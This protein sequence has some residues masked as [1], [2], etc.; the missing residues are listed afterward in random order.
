MT[1]GDQSTL[2]EGDG[3]TLVTVTAQ[4]Q[5]PTTYRLDRVVQVSVAGDGEAGAVDFAAVEDF[6]I[7]LT[8][9]VASSQATFTLTPESDIE[10]ETDAVLTISGDLTGVVTSG[11]IEAATLTLADDDAPPAG[12]AL[13]LDVAAAAASESTRRTGSAP[14]HT[15]SVVRIGA[16]VQGATRY[17]TD[18]TVMVTAVSGSGAS[19]AILG[20][21]FTTTRGIPIIIRA[22]EQTGE[23]T[24][25]VVVTAVDDML[26]ENEETFM[27][28]GSVQDRAQIA[29]TGVSYTIRDNDGAASEISLYTLTEVGEGQRR[30]VH[31]RAFIQGDVF[32]EAH[33]VKI[34]LTDSGVEG[35]VSYTLREGPM[36]RITI[37]ANKTSGFFEYEMTLADNSV[38]ELDEILTIS[39]VHV[40]P[41]G[42]P[43][44]VLP[45]RVR[46]IDNDPTPRGITLSADV[47]AVQEGASAATVTVTATVQGS[48]RF[49][50]DQTVTVS[51][52]GATASAGDFTASP[53]SFDIVIPAMAGSMN[54]TFTLTAVEDALYEGELTVTV[55]GLASN[56]PPSFVTA[57][58]ITLTDN[59]TPPA[60][61]LTVDTDVAQ[62]G[63]QT[64]LAEGAGVT[65]VSVTATVQGVNFGAPQT[66]AVQ[67]VSGTAVLNSDFTMP[68]LFSLQIPANT[69]SVTGTFMLLPEQDSRFEGDEMFAVGGTL[70][71]GGVAISITPANISLIDDDALTFGGATIDDQTYTQNTAIETLTLPAATGGNGAITYSLADEAALPTGLSFDGTARPPTITGTP[72]AVAASMMF[73]YTAMDADNDAVTLTFSITVEA[74]TAPTFGGATIDDQTYF[75]GTAIPTLT[76]PVATGGNGAITYSLADE[77]ALPARLIFNGTARPPTITGTPSAV[78]ASMMFTYTAMDTDNDAVTLT[79]SITVVAD[80]APTF[81]GATIDDQT[82]FVGTAIPTLTLPEANGGNGAITYTLTPALPDGLMWNEGTSPQTIAGEPTTATAAAVDFTYVAADTDSNNAADDLATLTF[83]IT[84]SPMVTGI[85]DLTDRTFNIYPNPVSGSLTVERKG[86]AGDEISIHDLTGK[87]IQVPVREQSPGKVV[88]DVSGLAGGMYLVR[89]SGNVSSMIIR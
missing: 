57:H 70:T 15:G 68:S 46:L 65:Q 6:T 3:P 85:D 41:T 64:T 55:S 18:L 38:D 9:G 43:L 84:V 89:V 14:V 1:A 81:G 30:T 82:Y 88:L 51:V 72:S 63:I 29:V 53:G 52:A 58:T 11:V 7:T 26:D 66:I 16:T 59:D 75:V 73:T 54:G 24:S 13:S 61:V 67:A 86:I 4:P 69:A 31:V 47:S 10:D 27:F 12:I 74:Y 56:Q 45:T 2:A 20:T 28:T 44:T 40:P 50:F 71:V 5:G 8:A 37:P 22:G 19:G 87:R 78:A 21:D 83:T 17:S 42:T 80:T 25:Y 60:I 76:L 48:T 33:T 35:A 39:G 23:Q 79:F 36:Q 77:A 62:A 34:T 32:S 49:N